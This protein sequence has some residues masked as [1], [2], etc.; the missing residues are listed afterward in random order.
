[1]KKTFL[2]LLIF[3]FILIQFVPFFFKKKSEAVPANASMIQVMVVPDDIKSILKKSC[4]DCHSQKTEY[5]W[6]SYLQPLGM[7]IDHHIEEGKEHF[8]MDDFASYS[9]EDQAH[10][11]KE[12]A[13]VVEEGEMPLKSYTI[14]HRQARLTP[15]EKARF[16]NW[17]NASSNG[18]REEANGHKE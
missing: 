1:M 3:A 15:D 16:I 14:M 7:W 10:L 12:L 17:A 11:L 4:A 13:E 2:G 6:Y 5:P 8:N 9:S 18:V